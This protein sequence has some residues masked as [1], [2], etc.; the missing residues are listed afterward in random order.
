M[1]EMVDYK[2]RGMC[3]EKMPVHE[4]K[5]GRGATLP[6]VEALDLVGRG[7]RDIQGGGVKLI[8]LS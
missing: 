7:L 1:G 3:V 6:L 4:F 2:R 8:V 5:G